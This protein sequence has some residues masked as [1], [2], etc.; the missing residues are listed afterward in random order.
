M[1]FSSEHFS[2]SSECLNSL[3][4]E[5]DFLIKCILTD[6]AK[7]LIYLHIEPNIL[8]L[9]IKK[10][11]ASLSKIIIMT[12][13][14]FGPFPT[15][16]ETLICYCQFHDFFRIFL[17]FCINQISHCFPQASKL[18]RVVDIFSEKL[19]RWQKRDIL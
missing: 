17:R 9:F 2:I 10:V 15:K 6:C 5:R 13:S 1:G 12:I 3:L 11:V 16:C 14:S 8:I 18:F 19:E 4:L 7:V